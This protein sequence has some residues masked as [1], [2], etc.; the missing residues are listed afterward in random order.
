M[1]ECCKSRLGDSSVWSASKA[2]FS[3]QCA[4]GKRASSLDLC[5]SVGDILGF[6]SRSKFQSAPIPHLLSIALSA[7]DITLPNFYKATLDRP[8]EVSSLFCLG[9]LISLAKAE[10]TK[11]HSQR[12]FAW[13]GPKACQIIFVISYPSMESKSQQFP[14]FPPNEC[15]FFQY[16]TF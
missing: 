14:G 3:T 9:C 4:L 7:K 15:W 16:H 8:V 6:V 5:C 10:R 12:L 11:I 1:M 13:C 2:D